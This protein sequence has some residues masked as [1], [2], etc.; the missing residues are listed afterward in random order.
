LI[1]MEGNGGGEIT[2]EEGGGVLLGP[3]KGR[4]RRGPAR[5]KNTVTKRLRT[6]KSQEKGEATS[7][8]AGEARSHG[9]RVF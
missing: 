2:G 3:N 6:S 4:K 1:C 8:A 5:G 7:P 9:G